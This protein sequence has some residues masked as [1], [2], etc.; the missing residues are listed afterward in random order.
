MTEGLIRSALR[1]RVLAD[2]AVQ[3]TVDE[4]WVPRSN[5]RADLVAVGSLLEGFEIKTDRDTLKRLPRQATAYGRVFDRCVA[6]VADRHVNGAAAIVPNWWGITMVSV[7]G[8]VEF[9]S[10]R[11]PQPNPTPDPETLVRLLWR[12]EVISA[13]RCMGFEP[14][15]RSPRSVLWQE[16]LGVATQAELCQIVRRAILT[17]NPARARIPTRRFTKQSP[18]ATG[19]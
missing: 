7:N 15:E 8:S 12:D 19:S 4:F 16:L 11:N 10:L 17:R 14:G 2:C 9:V 3:D 5:E 18:A 1:Q 13:L 6:V